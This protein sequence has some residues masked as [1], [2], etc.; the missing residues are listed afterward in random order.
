VSGPPE[1]RPLPA[2]LD[3]PARAARLRTALVSDALDRL[4]VSG[5]C[6]GWDIVPLRPGTRLVGRAFPVA[7]VPAPGRPRVPYRGLLE[8]LDRIGPHQVFVL[9]TGRSTRAAV[10]GELLSHA[11]SARG[12]SG[13]VTDGLVRDAAAVRPLGFPVF[14]RGTIPSD[15]N[16]RL[17]V[18]GVAERAVIDGVE[19]ERGCLLVGDDDGVVAVPPDL[20]DEVVEAALAKA[21]AEDRFREAVAA[22]E[23]PS[24]AYRRHRV[25]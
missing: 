4:G 1:A 18:T 2:G 8:A 10:W 24:V 14:A 5:R 25:L 19:V 6:L 22:G 7:C 16:G 21:R 11:C 12:A 9:P 17:E 13:A 15:I 20:E 3:D 23:L